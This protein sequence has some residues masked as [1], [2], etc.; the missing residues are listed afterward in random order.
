MAAGARAAN[1][2]ECKTALQFCPMAHPDW[3]DIRH[4]TALA[5]TLN[6]ARAA[7]E[8]GTSQVTVMR[9]VRALESALGATLFLRRRDG[10][11]L[12]SAGAEFH[13]ATGEAGE[14]IRDA[15]ARVAARDRVNSG[16][17]RIVTT[18][19]A[20]NWILLPA[21][22]AFLSAQPGLQIEIDASPAALSLVDDAETLAVR[23]RRPDRGPFRIRKLAEL[24]F[25]LYC[26]PG[27]PAGA[28]IDWA[29]PFSEITLARWLRRAH[30]GTE[31]TVAVTTFEGHIRAARAGRGSDGPADVRGRRRPSAATGRGSGAV[32]VASVAGRSN[33]D[34]RNGAC[35]AS[36]TVLDK[37]IQRAVAVKQLSKWVAGQLDVAT[38]SPDRLAQDDCRV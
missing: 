35:A 3:E 34:R 28:W 27:T 22:P 11:R 6:L 31:P 24:P 16:R 18:E 26:A 38:R 25:A 14:L 9:R 12:T 37:S 32:R 30:A 10:H 2:Q 21:L 17:V 7:A 23:F 4:F 13:A 1:R 33:T 8:L 29:G 20:A 36:I 5:R 19:L 15:V